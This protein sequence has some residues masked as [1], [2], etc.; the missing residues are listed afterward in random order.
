MQVGWHIQS[1]EGGAQR[2]EVVISSREARKFFLCV[3]F[4]DQEALS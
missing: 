1:T 4:S 2:C 3:L